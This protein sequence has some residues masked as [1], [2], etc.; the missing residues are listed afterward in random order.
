MPKILSKRQQKRGD[1]RIEQLKQKQE[2]KRH[3][4][5]KQQQQQQQEFKYKRERESKQQK[6]FEVKSYKLNALEGQRWTKFGQ[7]PYGITSKKDIL[8]AID[9]GG[10]I[11]LLLHPTQS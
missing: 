10:N 3:L 2:K 5:N 9:K 11:V 1:C 6:E 7:L 4:H 8:R